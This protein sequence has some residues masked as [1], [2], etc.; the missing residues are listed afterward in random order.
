MKKT[1]SKLNIGRRD[2]LKMFGIGSAALFT[3]VLGNFQP[4]QATETGKVLKPPVSGGRSRVAFTTGTDRRAMISEVMKP[5]EQQ[6]KKDMKG[7]Q[8]IIKPNMVQTTIP[9]C[10]THVDAIHGLLEFI[11]PLYNGQIIIAEATGARGGESSP[12][13]KNYGYLDLQKEYDLKF[14]DL[15]QSTG[16]PVWILDRDL[17]PDK[18]LVTSTFLD[19]KNYIISISRLKTHNAVVMTAGTKNMVMAAPLITPAI[20]GNPQMNYK[21]R[22]HS[23]GPRWLNYNMF[24]VAKQVR[25]D[26]TII[27]GVEGMQG[28]GPTGGTAVDHKIALA[29]DDVLAVDSMCAKLMGIPLEDIGYL[30]YC[31]ADGLGNIDREKI[32]II[33]NKDPNQYIIPYKLHDNIATQMS[34]KGT[35][36]TQK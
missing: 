8:L 26:F 35:F 32:D 24:L 23:G 6:L 4:V 1:E 25:P 16:I 21:S 11:K 19:P 5:F 2:A 28:N 29:G 7:K 34:W 17:H 15:N 10:A 12:G 20:N 33:G 14:V 9:L 3:G 13:F 31:A 18:I 27:D 36:N 22:M 30:N